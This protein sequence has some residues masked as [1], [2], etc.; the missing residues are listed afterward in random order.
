MEQNNRFQ[1]LNVIFSVLKISKCLCGTKWDER[2]RWRGNRHPHD[3]TLHAVYFVS[4]NIDEFPAVSLIIATIQ[5]FI[6]LRISKKKFLC[7]LVILNFELL[8]VNVFVSSWIE[9]FWRHSSDVWRKLIAEESKFPSLIKCSERK[10]RHELLGKYL[11]SARRCIIGQWWWQKSRVRLVSH[12][13]RDVFQEAIIF[14]SRVDP[15]YFRLCVAY[16][17]AV[18]RKMPVIRSAN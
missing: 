1:I 10:K 17:G 5:E 16:D 14:T 11:R 2:C 9:F 3:L 4:F 18:S 13:H 7:E 15:Y 6:K 12:V 8:D